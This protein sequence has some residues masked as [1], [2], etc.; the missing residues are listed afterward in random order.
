MV[1]GDLVSGYARVMALACH[2][3][4]P[5]QGGARRSKA[6]HT[7]HVWQS[8]LPSV[9]SW[10]PCAASD[11]VSSQQCFSFF[12]FFP[13]SLPILFLCDFVVCCCLETCL[14]FV[15][16]AFLVSF[17][18]PIF[19]QPLPTTLCHNNL[20]IYFPLHPPWRT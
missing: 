5:S 6:A 14:F 15:D 10:S 18:W 1:N 4:G 7:V 17:V 13:F 2:V 19:S 9:H 16:G 20:V 8:L 11:V 12:P 3:R